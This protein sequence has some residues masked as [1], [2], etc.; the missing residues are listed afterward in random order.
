ME[1]LTPDETRV[2]AAMVRYATD[3]KLALALGK[4]EDSVGRTFGRVFAKTGTHNKL[5]LVVKL[6]KDGVITCPCGMGGD[7]K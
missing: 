6:I 7:E 3:R 5:E 4:T 2:V 1:A